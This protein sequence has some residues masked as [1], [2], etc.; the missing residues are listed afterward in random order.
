MTGFTGT[1]ADENFT[2]TAAADT[3]FF[4]DDWGA[5]TLA[6]AGGTGD[7][8]DFFRRHR[9]MT[10]TF[11]ADGSVS[12]AAGRA[13]S[14]V[15]PPE[16]IIAGSGVTPSS[17]RTG[18]LR[19]NHRRRRGDPRFF[20]VHTGLTVHVNADGTLS[21]AASGRSSDGRPAW[22]RS[23]RLRRQRL[24][25]RRRRGFRGTIRR[26][27]GRRQHPGLLGLDGGPWPWTSPRERRGGR[28]RVQ[29][30]RRHRRFGREHRGRR[31]RGQRFHGRHAGD[32][33]IFADGWGTDAI[34]NPGSG[35][36]DALDFSGVTLDLS[37]TFRADGTIFV[38]DGANALTY[39]GDLA[40][41]TGGSGNNA[42]VFE[43]GAT[44]AGVIDGGEGGTNTMDFS[45]YA[46]PVRVDLQNGAFSLGGS[47]QG[48][49]MVDFSALTP[50]AELNS[51]HGID[52]ATLPAGTAL[53][54]L[55]V[56]SERITAATLLTSLNLGNGVDTV[57]G[58][59]L[60]FTLSTG[61]DV[62][63]DL[64][65]ATTVGGVIDAINAAAP[66]KLSASVNAAGNGLT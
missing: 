37:V 60:R 9:D 42:Y 40:A 3:Y 44:F 12:A 7:T 41:F 51:G 25:V 2:G 55:G 10:V 48:S 36:T 52:T 56:N 30:A 54:A 1:S 21:A 11:H 26:R 18:D 35:D 50:V 16:R 31:R 14:T 46:T 38:S 8:L 47:L 24:P 58:K 57:F 23:S 20:S 64:G 27:R 15:R 65:T 19:G 63:V 39:S 43:N 34:V 62:D 45:G 66:G 17:S 33:Y 6:D 61:E 49:S 22:P 53:A 29:H 28:G 5:D 4:S 13:P 59:D 32:V